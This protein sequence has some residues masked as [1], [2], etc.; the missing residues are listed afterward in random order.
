VCCKKDIEIKKV[1]FHS[2]RELEIPIHYIDPVL[3]GYTPNYIFRLIMDNDE[4]H[5]FK[6]YL[7]LLF[8]FFF[9][10]FLFF[11]LCISTL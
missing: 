11:F 1:P 4:T 10:F 9:Y 5:E 7:F 3:G 8:L 6:E 2:I